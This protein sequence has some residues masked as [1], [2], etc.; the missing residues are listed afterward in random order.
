MERIQSPLRMM[1]K[2]S[3][4]WG[5]GAKERPKRGRGPKKL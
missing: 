1:V 5:G 4:E 2:Y 3:D